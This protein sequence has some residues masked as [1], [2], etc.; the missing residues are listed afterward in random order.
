MVDSGHSNLLSGVLVEV[1]HPLG[2]LV[3]LSIGI[4]TESAPGKWDSNWP[5]WV[6][7]DI[8][9]IYSV[10]LS[11]SPIN[12]WTNKIK[13]YLHLYYAKIRLQS[14][15]SFW[16]VIIKITFKR[17]AFLH[18]VSTTDEHVDLKHWSEHTERNV[19]SR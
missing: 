6:S 9:R 17:E 18:L 19:L 11:L 10:F 1:T 3:S 12:K 15:S 2:V 7:D 14:Y 5:S 8:P 16:V 4:L 13:N